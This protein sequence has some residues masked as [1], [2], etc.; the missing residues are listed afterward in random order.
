MD[1][2]RFLQTGLTAGAAAA[3][4]GQPTQAQQPEGAASNAAKF[5]LKYAPHFG[6]FRHL[7][8]DNL[9]DQLKFAA[10]Q[11]FTA[12]EDN[13]MKGRPVELQEQIAKTMSELDMTMGVFVAT[14]GGG[15]NTVSFAG[16]NKDARDAV[17]ADMRASIDVAKRVHAK[18][19]TIV[20]GG[21]NT[22]LEM[23]YQMA[24]TID[25]LRRCVDIVEAHDLVMVMEPL[26]WWANHPGVF[27]T[28]IPQ[29]YEL[30]RAVDHPSCK[31]LF[32]LYHQQITEGN[33]IPNIDMSYSEVGY[34]QSGDTP[35]RKE[36]GTGEMNYRNIFRHLHK[37]GFDG[38]IGMEHGNSI[39]G[40]EGER[41]LIQAYREADN[42]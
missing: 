39:P 13:G 2:R 29:A 31:I 30:C 25:L 7:G 34:F 10:D 37:K 26:N 9:I 14:A 5:K 33:I 27:L 38:V 16:T 3:L 8:G 35:G 21:F 41:A 40:P 36:P 28:K 22:R 19:M 17:L 20:L 1:R 11:G 24:H 4:V 32:D 6:S 42:F 23:G 15:F 12:W 18:W